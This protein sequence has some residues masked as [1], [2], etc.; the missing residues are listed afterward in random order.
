MEGCESC[1]LSN[2]MDGHRF[3]VSIF[4]LKKVITK[5]IIL[6]MQF[7]NQPL[8]VKWKVCESCTLSNS[9]DGHRCHV[10]IFL[11]KKVIQKKG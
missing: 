9:M 5:R 10:S 1:T 3:H 2:S 6:D 8:G 4:L 7:P 11:L